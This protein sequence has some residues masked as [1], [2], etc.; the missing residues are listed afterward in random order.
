MICELQFPKMPRSKKATRKINILDKKS[1]KNSE[2]FDDGTYYIYNN[3]ETSDMEYK[4]IFNYVNPQNSVG[5][6]EE[7]SYIGDERSNNATVKKLVTKKIEQFEGFDQGILDNHDDSLWLNR[8][9]DGSKKV[10]GHI[11][12]GFKHLHAMVLVAS[13]T[14]KWLKDE[15]AFADLTCEWKNKS[16][17]R[18]NIVHLTFVDENSEDYKLQWKDMPPH[19]SLASFSKIFYVCDF[20]D[21]RY[22]EL[23]M[24]A[25]ASIPAFYS[26][27]YSD[28]LEYCKTFAKNAIASN[29][30]SCNGAMIDRINALAITGTRVETLSRKNISSAVIGNRALDS[31]ACKNLG[32]FIV[33]FLA[34]VC[35]SLF[36]KAV[37]KWFF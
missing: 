16:I 15:E 13:S 22:L 8:I 4:A 34:V 2:N 6:F 18:L 37:E 19:A 24:I 3:E 12:I 17:E 21:V 26:T 10:N 27:F 5:N 7:Y 23:Q 29:D 33:V 9:V 20:T 36:S 14:E 25:I 28:C 32:I 35:G 31:S 30:I 11:L 1:K